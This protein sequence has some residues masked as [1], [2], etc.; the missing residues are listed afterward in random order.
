MIDT[1]TRVYG[2]VG[3][4]IKSQRASLRV[5]KCWRFLTADAGVVIPLA[6]KG[7]TVALNCVLRI[8]HTAQEKNDM[9]KRRRCLP[10]SMFQAANSA[11][12]TFGSN[13]RYLFKRFH[14]C[15]AA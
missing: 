14:Y 2:V 9:L 1:R 5:P 8:G 3:D 15:E 6:K 10:S 7:R 12:T 11:V 4:S 13:W